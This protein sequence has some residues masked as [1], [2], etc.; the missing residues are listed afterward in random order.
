MLRILAVPVHRLAL[1]LLWLT[2]GIGA[3][4]VTASTV[5]AT[6]P[7]AGQL[8][9]KVQSCRQISSGKYAADEGG[10]RTI[11]VCG[12]VAGAVFWKADMDID[13]DG[14][15]TAHCNVTADPSFLS[16]T[17][18]EPGGKPLNAETTPYFVIA[19]R[20]AAF[21]YGK[22]GIQLG[23]VAA[24]VY[25]GKVAYAVFGDTGPKGILGE[26]SYAVAKL[27][28]INPDPSTGG[29]AS[30]VTYIVFANTR[31]ADPRSAASITAAG[32]AAAAK[33]LRKN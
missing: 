26:A 9:A 23:A 30:G 32:R 8:L 13:C 20:T 16:G 27:L 6:P 18:L 3:L 29:T 1:I 28:G 33:F 15:R 7:T 24:I 5:A 25:K 22:H 17:A 10:A 21:D 31:V 2:A 4:A 14:V 11:P 19:Q 12:G